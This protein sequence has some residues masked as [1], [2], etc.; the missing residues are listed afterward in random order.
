MASLYVKALIQST[1]EIVRWFVSH[2]T[3]SVSIQLFESELLSEQ[4][5]NEVCKEKVSEKSKAEIMA[6]GLRDKVRAEE[7]NFQKLVNVLEKN[8]DLKP[9]AN[10]L[11]DKLGGLYVVA[12]GVIKTEKSAN[13]KR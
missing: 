6:T 1:G 2:G 5:Y 8:L 13:V 9:L 7:K 10:F 12:E 4:K 3:Q 11:Q